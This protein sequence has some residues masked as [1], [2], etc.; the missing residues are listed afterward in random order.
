MLSQ[1]VDPASVHGPRVFVYICHVLR[2]S[3]MSPISS[4]HIIVTSEIAAIF[5]YYV[6]NNIIH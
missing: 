5:G 2:G 4:P 3:T 1:Q 6:K